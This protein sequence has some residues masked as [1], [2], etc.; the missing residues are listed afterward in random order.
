[1]Y[2]PNIKPFLP[3]HGVASEFVL[4][5]KT[6]CLKSK[7][8]CKLHFDTSSPF[9]LPVTVYLGRA[10]LDVMIG[11]IADHAYIIYHDNVKLYCFAQDRAIKGEVRAKEYTTP[12]GG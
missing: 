3:L 4:T 12:T 5:N 8:S 6:T 2:E 11:T 10:S 1:M 7:L 9:R